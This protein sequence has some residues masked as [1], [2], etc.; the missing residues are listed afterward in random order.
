LA[1]EVHPEG[2]PVFRVLTVDSECAVALTEGS[3][4][5]GI[6]RDARVRWIDLLKQDG[7]TLAVL[8]ERFGFHPLTLEDCLHFDQRP[9]LEPYDDYLFLVLHGF[10]VDWDRIEH[11]QAEELHMFV[12]EGFVVT[13]HEHPLPALEAVWNRVAHD[14]RLLT[15]GADQLC[16]II[17]DALIDSYFPILDDLLLR[18]DQLEDRVLDHNDVALAEILAF[19]RLLVE[20]RKIL[21]PQR[22]VLALLAKHGDGLI[23]E[24]VSIYFRDVYDH[25]LRLHES[26]ESARELV[27]NVRDAH[28]WN[29]S[30]RTNE[31]MKRLTILSA[32]F[33]P[34][35]F[36]TGF[37]GQNFESLPF[38]SATLMY[39][40]LASCVIVPASM[41]LYFVR[42]KWF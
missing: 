29:A 38:E 34:L 11:A 18:V 4:Q 37:F 12:G 20:L 14:G 23:S 15:S 40:A 17:A 16:Y 36:I 5:V 9:K 2:D 33:L 28:L 10:S 13:V 1:E 42:S 22:D 24:R 32:I 8:S 19:K 6:D 25:A 3:D 21:S 26:V 7:S 41:L 35:T 39:L 27:G 30:Q 31:I